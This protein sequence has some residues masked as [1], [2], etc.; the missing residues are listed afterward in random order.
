MIRNKV[1]LLSRGNVEGRRLV[2][3]MV[4]GGLEAVD[5]YA[6]TKR[7]AHF[8]GRVVRVGDLS[9]Q[10]SE[11]RDIY[12]VGAGKATFPIAKVLEEILGDRIRD[13]VINV[14]RGQEGE[15]KRVRILRA[16][17]PVPD[18]EGMRGAQAVVELARNVKEGDLVFCAITGGSSALMPLPAPGITLEE[19]R[20]VT[21]L[22]LRSGAVI[23]EINAVRKHIS[24]IK[25]GRLALLLGK[26]TIINLTVSDVIGDWEDLDCIT[27]NTVPDRSTFTDAVAVLKKYD[28]W[29]KV[30][31]SVR[32][33]LSK[34]DPKEETP[35]ALPGIEIH[36]FML[37]TNSDACEGAR[38]RGEEL[39]LHSIILSTVVEGES[40][41]AGIVFA[42][43]AKEVEARNRPV[44]T[45]CALISGG[46]TTVT[47]TDE[48]GEGGPNQEF[49]LGLALKIDGRRNITAVA[50]GTDGTDGPTDIAGGVVDGYTVERA[51]EKGIDVFQELRRHNAS[52]VFRELGD[53]IYS[54]ATGT[55]VMNLRIIVVTDS[56][57]K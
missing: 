27:D 7:L 1:E 31:E 38:R 26:A 51:R 48:H 2:L 16:S 42:G 3:D 8:D 56:V 49:A 35:K 20:T 41:E 44:K 40:R 55:N 22:L 28:L 30:P 10:S 37:A 52:H 54:G 50:L 45:P 25:G 14:K 21:E 57:G 39:G 13:G 33:R 32:S 18:E 4:E 15:L 19:K 53:A 23:R 47:I 12:V 5:P 11:I 17:H 9:Y 36:T 43:M 29:E 34:A 46:E 24:A 6:A